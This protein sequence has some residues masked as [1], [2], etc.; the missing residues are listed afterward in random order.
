MVIVEKGKTSDAMREERLKH[1]W[2][3]K[4]KKYP[5]PFD[6]GGLLKSTEDVVAIM[7]KRGVTF[8]GKRILDIGCGTG[9]FALPLSREAEWVTGLDISEAMLAI[10]SKLIAKYKIHN[11]DAVSASWGDL[12]ISA[13][14]FEK[15]FD[16]VLTT[17]SMAVKD[18]DD[19]VKMEQCAREWCM[20]VGWGNKR[21]NSLMEEV[22]REHGITLKPPPG[23]G[24]IFELLSKMGR[25]PS[26]DFIETFWNWQ[27]TV[28]EAFEDIAGHVE[29]EG[30]GKVPD[31]K[32]IREI[33]EKHVN[34]TMVQHTTYVEEGIIVWRVA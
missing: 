27:G 32:I 7:K 20:Y 19:L 14:G 6:N 30:Y 5:L 18:K 10:F 26:L 33:M 23:A 4:A 11:V 21:K 3:M 12:N 16:I 25:Q 2:E 1:F 29:L 13:H 22:F 15:A 31:K 34:N 8:A 24:L 28:D 17:M 9:M